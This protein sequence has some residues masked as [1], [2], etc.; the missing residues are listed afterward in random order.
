[1][2]RHPVTGDT[3][4]TVKA[5]QAEHIAYTEGEKNGY[6]AGIGPEGNARTMS[7][8]VHGRDVMAEWVYEYASS[9]VNAWKFR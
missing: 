6:P 3:L 1:M 9:K 5:A 7:A 4:K 8:S 2:P